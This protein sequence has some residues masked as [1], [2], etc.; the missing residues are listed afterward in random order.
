VTGVDEDYARLFRAEFPHVRRTIHVM[1]GSAAVAEDITQ[2]A[3]VQALLHWGKVSRF[4]RPDAWVR[5]VAIRLAVRHLKREGRRELVESSLEPPYERSEPDP[6]VGAAIRSLPPKQRAVLVL[7]YYE[8]KPMREIAYLLGMSESTG[9][10]HLHRA[11][12]R[13]AQLLG[14]VVVNAARP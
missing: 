8:D 4:D 3:F 10:V 13:L 11:R 2:D 7:F 5:R 1:V 14:E 12:R 9:F 6:E